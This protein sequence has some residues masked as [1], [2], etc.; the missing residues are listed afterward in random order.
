LLCSRAREEG[1][2]PPH[3]H[4]QPSIHEIITGTYVPPNRTYA[5][6]YTSNETCIGTV[7]IFSSPVASG[8]VRNQ[9]MTAIS[10]INGG[11]ECTNGTPV[12]QAVTRTG[13]YISMLE[14]YFGVPRANWTPD[15]ITYLTPGTGCNICKGD[16]FA[17]GLATNRPVGWKPRIL[18]SLNCPYYACTWSFDTSTRVPNTC[19]L[20]NE[21]DTYVNRLAYAPDAATCQAPPY[22]GCKCGLEWSDGQPGCKCCTFA[23]PF[24]ANSPNA[25][26]LCKNIVSQMKWIPG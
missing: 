13:Y 2:P 15:E 6:T 9:F 19:V 20:Y 22:N 12:R 16:P 5:A 1:P 11:V 17:L 26:Q 24:L 18:L 7:N 23:R 21:Q 14:T 8:T 25:A 3:H 10:A 4:H